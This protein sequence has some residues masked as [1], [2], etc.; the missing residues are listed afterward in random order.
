MKIILTV[1][2]VSISLFSALADVHVKGYTR[3]DGTYVAPHVRSSPNST[4][5]DNWSTKGNVNPYTGKAGTKNATASGLAPSGI[6]EIPTSGLVEGYVQNSDI[7]RGLELQ[8]RAHIYS[9]PRKDATLLA[10]AT[11]GEKIDIRGLEGDWARI[12]FHKNRVVPV[13]IG[14]IA[15]TPVYAATEQGNAD[16]QYNLGMKYL[17]GEGVPRDYPEAVNLFQLAAMQG[18][19]RAQFELGAM[20]RWG[21]GVEYSDVSAHVWWNI[22]GVKGHKKAKKYLDTLE[23]AMNAKEKIEAMKL[24]RE[25]FVKLPKG[26]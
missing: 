2:L 3:K 13:A 24:A 19:A 7:T 9:A 10:V 20:Y 8:E 26:N 22:A 21:K 15:N 25:L 16:A 18:D 14:A 11:S 23:S 1:L 12:D 17:N 6:S 5:A 4:N